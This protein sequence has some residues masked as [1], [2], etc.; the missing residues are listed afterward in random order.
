MMKDDLSELNILRDYVASRAPLLFFKLNRDGGIIQ[1]NQFARSVAG[2]LPDSAR[3]SDLVLDFHHDFNLEKMV[4]DPEKEYLL[5]LATAAGTPQS[6]YFT[7]VPAADCILVFGRADTD[8]VEFMRTEMLGLNQELNNLTRRLHKQNAQLERLNREKNQFLGMAAHDLRKP[9]GLVM[10]YSEFLLDDT[11]TLDVEQAQFV[12]TINTSS[13]F[14]KRL[15][16]DFLDVSAI[17]AGKF[18]IHLS[19]GNL[20]RVLEQ[21]LELN[22]FQAEK[23]KVDLEIRCREKLPDIRMD[24]PKIEQAITNLVSNAIEHT[25]PDSRVSI[26]LSCTSCEIQFMVQDEGPGIPADEIGNLFQPFGKTSTK[27]TAG[28]KSTGLGMLITRKII[29]AHQGRIWVESPAGKGAAFYFILPTGDLS[30]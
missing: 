4:S 7:F 8:E 10:S 22:R 18:D 17:E 12:R 20:F 15:V 23:K 28:E 1:S 19:P 24:A 16:D 11:D 26:T 29:E 14:M 30:P 5:N 27:K 6:F 25:P 2:N 13:T 3:F 21:S 9:I